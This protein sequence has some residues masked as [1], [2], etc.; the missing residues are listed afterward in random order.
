MGIADGGIGWIHWFGFVKFKYER[1][2]SDG[3][4]E[5]KLVA[6]LMIWQFN[7]VN[8][9]V[10]LGDCFKQEFGIVVSSEDFGK[11]TDTFCC[12]GI[13]VEVVKDEIVLLQKAGIVKGWSNNFISFI[14]SDISKSCS[15]GEI[16]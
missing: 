12:I 6:F 3:V 13:R 16:E 9:R 15:C 4:I 1:W 5:G 8:V 7:G 2:K 14:N 11:G 10:T